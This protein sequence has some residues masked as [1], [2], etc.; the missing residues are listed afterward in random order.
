LLA[1]AALI[2]LVLAGLT[3]C[4][5]ETRPPLTVLV[6]ATSAEPSPRVDPTLWTAMR[7]HASEAFADHEGEVDVIVDGGSAPIGFDLTPMRQNGKVE[8]SIEKRGPLIEERL[9]EMDEA[10]G[11]LASNAEDLDLLGLLA[12]AAS[13]SSDS[14]YVLSS[15]VQ[16]VDPVDIAKLGWDFDAEEVAG[17]LD[18][19]DY[20]PD[21]TGKKIV[22]LGLGHT[23][24]SQPEPSI[25]ARKALTRLWLA[26]CEHAGA[27]ECDAYDADSLDFPPISTAPVPVVAVPVDET[28]CTTP[29]AL[30]AD[31]LFTGGSDAFAGDP[32]AALQEIADE[33]KRCPDGVTASIIGHAAPVGDPAFALTISRKRADRVHEALLGMGVPASVFAVVDG[34]GD[35]QP[36]VDNYP[37]GVF[38]ET[39]ARQN[40]RV[41]ITFGP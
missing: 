30:S 29:R 31:L 11:R 28:P 21:V 40:R 26:I 22:F 13:T 41:E 23:A 33:L 6:T 14:V 15:G 16:T 2:P 3:A 27:D 36:V 4:S 25:S 32:T 35:T 37:D 18:D 20:L 39:L 5:F 10:I 38:S 7:E 24:G 17:L 8:Q 12:V 9:T 19:E 34:V 1:L